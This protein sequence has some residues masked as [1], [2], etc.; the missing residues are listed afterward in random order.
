MVQLEKI[1]LKNLKEIY[2]FIS[3][4]NYQS[5]NNNIRIYHT[6]KWDIVTLIRNTGL[7]D[8]TDPKYLLIYHRDKWIKHI[9]TNKQKKTYD[10]GIKI[11][12][13]EFTKFKKKITLDFR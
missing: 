2:K 11:K 9:A 6:N 7:V 3:F 4:H 13:V 12:T 10:R 1:N 5:S 8:E